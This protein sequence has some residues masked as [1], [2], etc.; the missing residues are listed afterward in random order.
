MLDDGIEHIDLSHSTGIQKLEIIS[1]KLDV[2]LRR[3]TTI[4]TQNIRRLV[5]QSWEESFPIV[6]TYDWAALDNAVSE[7][8]FPLLTHLIVNLAASVIKDWP[9][10][11]PRVSWDDQKQWIR[12]D[13][14]AR[15]PQLNAQLGS[16]LHFEQF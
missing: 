10:V 1:S 12:D 9:G 7:E 8:R 4:T 5:F 11:D 16:N 13:L 6:D 14:R 3:I 2:F 15:L